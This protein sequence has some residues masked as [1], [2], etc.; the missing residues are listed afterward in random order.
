MFE[1][2]SFLHF[3]EGPETV[4]SELALHDYIQNVLSRTTE[5]KTQ[6]FSIESAHIRPEYEI[7]LA[8]HSEK[9]A[10]SLIAWMAEK[11][12]VRAHPKHHVHA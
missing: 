12:A 6:L 11:D 8:K 5:P 10:M 2:V 3:L 9:L 4:G 7:V 1:F